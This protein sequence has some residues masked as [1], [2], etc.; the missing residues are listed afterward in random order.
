MIVYALIHIQHMFYPPTTEEYVWV[1]SYKKE[2]LFFL[3]AHSPKVS[4]F[5]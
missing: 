1:F 2:N 4:I 5:P 3:P